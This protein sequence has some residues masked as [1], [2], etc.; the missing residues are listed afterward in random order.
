MSD[1]IL[2]C[3]S[4]ADI[5]KE[6][7]NKR[8]I[9]YTCFHYYLDDVEY[10]DDLGESI[11]FD[12]F[13]SR[14]AKGA[15]TSTSQPNADQFILFFEPFLKE[16]KDVLHVS[17]STGLSG[18]YNSACIAQEELTEKYPE[19]KIIVIDSLAASSGY[20]LLMDM[21][22]DRR[23]GGDTIEETAQWIEEHRLNLHHWFFSTD[24]TFYYKG[25]RISKSSLL[26]GSALNICPLLNMN[27]LGQL[28]PRKKLRGKKRVIEEIV[29]MMK[30]HAENGADYNGKCYICQSAFYEDAGVVADMVEEAF[31]QLAE[32][33][34][35]NH[36]G[37]VIG[38]HTGP[39][40]IALFFVGDK[41][42]D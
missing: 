9:Y 40:T 37:T 15:K 18:A 31:P 12:E 20:G 8:S 5:S 26:F 32:P 14:M 39:G 42:V 41:R 35:I 25:G 6:H 23:D 2:S 13:Y 11:P 33:V 17:L 10:A 7:F 3:C 38:S 4:T 21:A 28:M 34:T 27:D 36:I 1:Y 19:R 16:G 30:E 24:L 29:K 22:A